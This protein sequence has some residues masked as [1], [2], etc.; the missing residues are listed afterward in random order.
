LG[1]GALLIP[2]IG[3]VLAIGPAAGVLAGALTGG[4]A[5]AMIDYGLPEERTDYYT[6][7]VTEG[8]IMVIL[9]A[10]EEKIDSAARIMRDAGTS[11]VEVH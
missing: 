11:E 1:A 4:L 8:K 3:P 7:K 6:Q 9:Q 5:G 10:H 2:G